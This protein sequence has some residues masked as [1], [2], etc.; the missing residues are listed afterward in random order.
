MQCGG[1]K[2]IKEWDINSSKSVQHWIVVLMKENIH[3]IS[4]TR[5]TGYIPVPLRYNTRGHNIV[6]R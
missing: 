5:V 4:T 1:N 3:H 6:K 2:S